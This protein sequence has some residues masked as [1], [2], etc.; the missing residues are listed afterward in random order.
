MFGQNIT[1]LKQLGYT[2]ISMSIEFYAHEQN[3]GYQYF[4]IYDGTSSNS[5][6]LYDKQFEHSTDSNSSTPQKYIFSNIEI[7]LDDILS[8]SVY[9]RYGASG[10]NEDTWFNYGV[11]VNINIY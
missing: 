5:T 2:K 9:I 8:N 4:W 1:N 3:D 10:N 6:I 11:A 7:E